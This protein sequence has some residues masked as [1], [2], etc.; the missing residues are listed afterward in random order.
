MKIEQCSNIVKLLWNNRSAVCSDD[1]SQYVTLQNTKSEFPKSLIPGE[2]DTSCTAADHKL[3]KQ[4][5]MFIISLQTEI[6]TRQHC[7]YHSL[8]NG[9][10]WKFVHCVIWNTWIFCVCNFCSNTS[11]N[12]QIILQVLGITASVSLCFDNRICLRNTILCYSLHAA[13]DSS[14]PS[15]HSSSPSHFHLAGMQCPLS[16]VK[17]D[18]AQ[19]FFAARKE[20]STWHEYKLCRRSPLHPTSPRMIRIALY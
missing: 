2:C 1:K 6:Q 15:G 17:S 16:Q 3:D 7:L 14:D 13:S 10:I 12:W 9:Y 5:K 19:V 18:S 11:I 4:L 20:E 8:E